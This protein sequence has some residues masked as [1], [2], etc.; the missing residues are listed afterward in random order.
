MHIRT[1]HKDCHHSGDILSSP[2]NTHET[3]IG[4]G[5]GWQAVEG[6][7]SVVVQR[8]SHSKH[9]LVRL[10]VLGSPRETDRSD[11]RICTSV[12][13]GEN[14]RLMS[15]LRASERERAWR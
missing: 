6:A 13:R 7:G 1:P 14:V 9:R 2:G 15:K 11:M 5:A 12:R 8:E 4:L 3:C 10:T